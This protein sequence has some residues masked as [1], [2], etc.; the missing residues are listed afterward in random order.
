MLDRRHRFILTPRTGTYDGQ[1]FYRV[2]DFELVTG[3]V[4]GFSASPEL[5]AWPDGPPMSPRE[6]FEVALLE[7]LQRPPCVV[8]FSGGRDSSAALAVA[9][10]LARREGLP[11]PIAATHDFTG[12]GVADETTYQEM[13]IRSLRLRDWHRI[14]EPDAFDILGSRA[15]DG[16]RRFGLLWPALIHFQSPL[17]EL[18]AGGG[19]FVVGEGGDEVLGNQRI[20]PLTHLVRT[21]RPRYDTLYFAAL[22]Q[23]VLPRSLRLAQRR[24]AARHD[25]L[26]PWLRADVQR[27]FAREHAKVAVSGPWRWDRSVMRHPTRRAVT[28]AATNIR[29]VLA[30]VD[31]SYHMPFLHPAFVGALAREG[32]IGGYITRTRMM[33]TFFGDVVPDEICR[34]DEKARFGAVAVGAASRE[35]MQQ[36]QG[37]GV[38][39]DIVDVEAFRRAALADSP[40]FG[41]QLLVQAAWLACQ[42]ESGAAA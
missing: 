42:P 15:T 37:E 35:F 18:A 24:Y 2:S 36:W 25:E 20:T 31:V 27:T 14:A 26:H 12:Q 4:E 40:L 23:A 29:R 13:V 22:M 28:I 7:A 1:G 30:S 41:V 3:W 8:A 38:D 21:K 19:S 10:H 32:G 9:T 39:A 6:G 34:R 5:T 16:L 33:R 17:A 11:E